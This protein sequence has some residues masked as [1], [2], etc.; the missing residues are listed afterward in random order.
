M[1]INLSPL[2]DW[3]EGLTSKEQRMER[4]NTNF[5]VEKPDKCHFNQMIRVKL[6]SLVVS[7]GCHLPP[8]ISDE[9]GTLYLWHSFP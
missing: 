7:W 9:K 1:K 4:K 2:P 8:D 3:S 6:T 5:T